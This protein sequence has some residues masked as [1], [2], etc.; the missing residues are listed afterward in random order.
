MGMVVEAFNAEVEGGEARVTDASELI[1]T[2]SKARKPGGSKAASKTK[3]V[4]S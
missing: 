3:R 4:K 1:E 2:A